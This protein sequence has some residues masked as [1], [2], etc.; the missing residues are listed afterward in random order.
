MKTIIAI[1]AGVNGA[2]AVMHQE[3]IFT[4]DLEDGLNTICK[5]FAWVKGMDSVA[6][7]EKVGGY[8][9]KGDNGEGQPG[10]RMFTFGQSYG[11]LEGALAGFKI[12]T[13]EVVPQVWQ[14]G[15]PGR[16]G[17]YAERKRALRDHAEKLFPN[18]VVTSSNADALGLLHYA[19]Y[20][21]TGVSWA[22]AV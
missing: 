15:V 10:S 2:I 3:K 12:R 8:I 14:R 7:L 6:Y 4:I 13:V 16:K 18:L 1:D 11:Q 5:V 17:T 9:P 22:Y 20:K 21:E 19:R